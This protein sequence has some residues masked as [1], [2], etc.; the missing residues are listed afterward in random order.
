[1]DKIINNVDDCMIYNYAQAQA[2][3]FDFLYYDNSKH[4]KGEVNEALINALITINEAL[5]KGTNSMVYS[6][7]EL[8]FLKLHIQQLEWALKLLSLTN[9][10]EDQTQVLKVLKEANLPA[11]TKLIKSKIGALTTRF[12]M[13]YAEYEKELK[14]GEDNPFKAGDLL[15]NIAPMNII[16]EGNFINAKTTSIRDFMNYQKVVT[17]K[18]EN[19]KRK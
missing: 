6:L 3:K 15:D 19:I 9:V 5:E 16:L 1:M 10:L 8:E 13:K 7:S 12:R 11:T 14:A 4:G 2:G 17:N 18:I